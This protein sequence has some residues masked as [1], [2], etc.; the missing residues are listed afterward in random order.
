[1]VL[2]N[3]V[4][5]F[6]RPIKGTHMRKNIIMLASSVAVGLFALTSLQGTAQAYEYRHQWQVH[7]QWRYDPASA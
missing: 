5:Y 2:S 6:Q 4:E 3:D 1:M 7:P